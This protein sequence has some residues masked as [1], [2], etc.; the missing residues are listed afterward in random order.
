MAQGNANLRA[1]PVATGSLRVEENDRSDLGLLGLVM[2]AQYHEIAADPK[3]LAHHFGLNGELFDEQTL[4]LAA[5]QLGLKARILSQP[6]ARLDKITLPA[7]SL[8]PDGAH[9]IVAKVA[10]GNVLIHDLNLQRPQ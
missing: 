10:D 3:Q 1:A 7:L 2:L 4:L 6:V 8:Q 5:K 9:F